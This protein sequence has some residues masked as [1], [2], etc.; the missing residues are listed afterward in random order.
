MLRPPA[1]AGYPAAEI[2]EPWRIV[3][4]HQFHDVLPGSSIALVYRPDEEAYA[5]SSGGPRH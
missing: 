4:L 1:G 2:R 5:T 3:P